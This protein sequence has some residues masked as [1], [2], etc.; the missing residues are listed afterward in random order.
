MR[1]TDAGYKPLPIGTRNRPWPTRQRGEG[2]GVSTFG[3]GV[4][5]SDTDQLWLHSA[6]EYA[7]VLPELMRNMPV[8]GMLDAF[9]A[10]IHHP[11]VYL[12]STAGRRVGTAYLRCQVSW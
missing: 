6:R 3:M 7:H 10:I 11:L 4:I 5:Q 9:E 2:N 8:P 12:E 1:L